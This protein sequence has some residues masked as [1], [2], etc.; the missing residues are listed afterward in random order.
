[1]TVLFLIT[2]S[3]YC[4]LNFVP[5]IIKHFISWIFA[6]NKAEYKL[7]NEIL[8]LKNEMSKI[9]H[10]D[11]FS[12]YSKLQR[13]HTTLIEIYRKEARLSYRMKVQLVFTYLIKILNWVI[14]IM[15]M[16]IYQKE[17]IVILPKGS[18]HPFENFLSWPRMDNTSIS[19]TM[20]LA[21]N[22]IVFTK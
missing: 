12:K 2:T 13:K 15:L 20:W 1:M 7:K 8:V 18:L 10:V 4:F 17:P 21:I 19:L 14:L 9:S 5:I 6:E 16:K 11:E 22:C 3:A